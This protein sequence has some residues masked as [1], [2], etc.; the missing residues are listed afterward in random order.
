MDQSIAPFISEDRGDL[1]RA[2]TYDTPGIGRRIGDKAA[3]QLPPIGRP[4]D[5]G[6]AAVERAVD[7]GDASWQQALS[8]KERLFGA[9]VEEYLAVRHK[10]TR[11]PAF[12]GRHRIG[13]GDEPGHPSTVGNGAQRMK[14]LAR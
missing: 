13:F 11:N 7:A 4:Y 12:F 1:A 8:G 10:L 14:D 3:A 9:R 6:V 2:L 5:H